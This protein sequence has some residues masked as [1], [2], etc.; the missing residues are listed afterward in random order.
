LLERELTSV[1]S[2]VDEITSPS[3]RWLAYR[4]IDRRIP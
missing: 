1:Q 2:Y 4:R 3:A